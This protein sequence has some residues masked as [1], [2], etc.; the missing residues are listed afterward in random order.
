MSSTSEESATN[1]SLD[2]LESLYGAP[3]R[4]AERS[5]PPRLATVS[6]AAFAR[7][8]LDVARPLA[9]PGDRLESAMSD[10][11]RRQ[12]KPEA[13]PEPADLRSSGL[14]RL[15]AAGAIGVAVAIAIAAVVAVLFV[16]LFPREKDAIQ[17]FAAAAPPAASP[18]AQQG[19][20]TPKLAASQLRALAPK[21]RGGENITHEQSERLLQQF[22]QWRQKTALIDKP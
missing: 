4:P 20:D 3:R 14:R 19:S 5:E 12:L 22:V 18:P 10:F 11:V 1:N 6:E 16:T 21:D 15:F 7:A 9:S 13:V 17:S 8:R 2:A